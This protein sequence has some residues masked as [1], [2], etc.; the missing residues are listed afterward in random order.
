M[1]AAA[2]RRR[3]LAA[4]ALVAL[5]LVALV[6][7]AGCGDDDDD[8]GG[9]AQP[10]SSLTVFAAASLTDV[11]PQ[12]EPGAEYNF[13]ASDTLATQI[14][15]GAPADVYAAANER[16]PNELFDEGLVDQPITFATNELVL[17]VQTG[18][19]E[20]IQG[21][22]DL[23]KEGVTFVMADEGVPV[24]DYTRDV[25]ANLNRSE[26]VGRAASQ[27]DDVRAVTGKVALGEADA[28]FAYATD[29][30]A[31]AEDV[32]AV[33]IPARAQPPINYG[34]A[35]VADSE[36]K[37]AAQVFIDAVLSPAGQDALEA[38]GFGVP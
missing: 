11:F 15:E 23:E 12:I 37:E 16:L 22:T 38:A 29:A 30:L 35:V 26:L 1:S 9:G 36:D 8:E 34:I 4:L 3:L 28:G 2:A 20:G 10:A 18:N 21:V 13:A 19:P 27:E 25:L 33:A 5:A 32:E 14:R 7:M 6:V 24:G 31:V 17:L